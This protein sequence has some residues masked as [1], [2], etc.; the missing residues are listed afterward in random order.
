VTTSFELTQ[1]QQQAQDLLGGD[2]RHN[3]LVG[4]SRSGK[5]FL[6]CRAIA[7][8]AMKAP[9]S[10]HLIARFRFNHVKASIW[11]DTWP[12]MMKL[13]FPAMAGRLKYDKTD[14]RVIFPNESEV[15]FGGL[16]DKERTE[17]ILGQEYATIYPNE[18]SQI[19]WSAIE[20][21]RTR[22]AQRVTYTD[23][24]GGERVLKLKLYYDCNPP[25]ATHWSHKLF[26]EHRDPVPPYQ[27]LK[28]PEQ[29]V[30]LRINPGDNTANLPAE[31]LDEL[32]TL[33][34]R[35]KRRFLDGE[36]GSASENA[37][38]TYEVIETHRRT[39]YPD[40]Q[41]VIIGV[42]PSGT[43][44]DEDE[45]SDHVGVVVV[46]LGI[47]G[48]AYVLEDLTIK[49]P[50]EIWGRVAVQAYMRHMADCI[51]A[52]TNFGGAMVG[53]VIRSASAAEKV[54][55]NYR[56]VTASRGKVVRGEPISTLYEQG[57]VHHVGMHPELEDQLCAF[58]T[59]GYMGDRSPDRA[60][61]AIWALTDL[62]PGMTRRAPRQQTTVENCG[63]YAAL[64]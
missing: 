25:L 19:G 3:L 21:L 63:T 22:L 42:D 16:D 1:R 11:S 17:K 7:M 31:Y 30:W 48:H 32:Q 34:A 14:T 54:S 45:R 51:V 57:K 60:D 59:A 55:V 36:W 33:G 38:W 12:K 27:P 28:N 61:A 4:G 46:G 41:R 2:A 62:F 40:L 53:S 8:R 6:L 15:W 47:D 37:L 35:A 24:G 56:E 26:V 58:T 44:G 29:Y 64:S 39:D 5:T 49:A 10:R 9:G 43:H 18:C 50:P 20:T 23:A 52:E 13:C